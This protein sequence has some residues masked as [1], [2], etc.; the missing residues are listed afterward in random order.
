MQ[1]H[2]ENTSKRCAGH[3]VVLAIQDTSYL[4][5]TTRPK[6]TGLTPINNMSGG[7]TNQG[8]LLHSTL[9]VTTHGV[10]LGILDQ[11][12]WLNSDLSERRLGFS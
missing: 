8:L 7:A 1:P 4:T 11:S 3:K 9:A 10:P 12:F 2:I 5:Y 6:V